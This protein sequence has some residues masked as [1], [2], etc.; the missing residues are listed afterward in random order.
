MQITPPA[1]VNFT[2]ISF[3]LQDNITSLPVLPVPT[4]REPALPSTGWA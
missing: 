2:T 3:A 1:G 4:T